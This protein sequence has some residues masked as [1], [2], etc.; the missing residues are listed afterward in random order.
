M[1]FIKNFLIAGAIMAI[2]THGTS[3]TQEG[4][5]KTRAANEFLAEVESLSMRPPGEYKFVVYGYDAWMKFR[6]NREVVIE[7][8]PCESCEVMIGKL[9]THNYTKEGILCD[10]CIGRQ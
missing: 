2:E 3:Q 7:D 10:G 5:E 1:S 6:K 9:E 8:I 4:K